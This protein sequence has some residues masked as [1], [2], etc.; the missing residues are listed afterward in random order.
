MQA[1]PISHTEIEA[2]IAPH[3]D[4]LLRL[5]AAEQGEA[6][7]RDLALMASALPFARNDVM[8]VLDLCC[9]PGDAGRAIQRE[10][11]NAHV[12]GVDRDP[13]LAA[14]CRSVNRQL[15]IPGE[16]IVGDLNER[17][18]HGELSTGYD[19]AVIANALHWFDGASAD[20]LLGEVRGLLR[21]GG[22]FL[23]AEPVW[24]A[25]PFDAGF[26]AWK[27]TLPPRY[28]REA[29]ERL[30]SSARAILGYDPVSLW[31]ARPTDRLG[32]ENITVAGWTALL[33]AAG[34]ESIDVLLRDADGVVL[35]ALKPDHNLR[36]TQRL[37]P[38]G[39]RR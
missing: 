27:A 29:W 15:G 36:R 34:F 12:D 4:E 38:V 24:T 17:D 39:R 14:L 11:P 6:K 5:W 20:R 13:F 1:P 3:L 19:V 32:D 25:K 16:T 10:Y 18:W 23:L 8:H 7:G 9:G 33:D 37:A 22:V 21:D 31:G 2:R 26:E 35:A 30:W 28:T